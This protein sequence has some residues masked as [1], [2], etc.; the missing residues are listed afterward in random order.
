VAALIRLIET[1]AP[2]ELQVVLEHVRGLPFSPSTL[3]NAVDPQAASPARTS[4]SHLLEE[5]HPITQLLHARLNACVAAYARELA[6][7]HP[8]FDG[9]PLPG[10][11][12]F[13]HDC[14]VN[15]AS[16]AYH[17]VITAILYLNDGFSGGETEFVGELV[18]P[19]PGHAV[20]FP[21]NWCFP[22]S[23]REVS[24]G[25]KYVVVTWFHAALA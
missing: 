10:G 22:H 4:G 24:S 15:P 25:E 17:R 16:S 14:D 9:P 20:V 6:A 12:V 8:A 18:R 5:A 13:H 3:A 2:E 21:S 1:L 23:G 7:L 19:R 11:Y